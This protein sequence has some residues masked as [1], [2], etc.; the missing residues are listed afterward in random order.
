L[1]DTAAPQTAQ[2]FAAIQLD[3]TDEL[4]RAVLP[5]LLALDVPPHDA[6]APLVAALRGWSGAMEMN[7]AQPLIFNAWM[8]SFVAAVQRRNKIP[9]DDDA[10][11]PD[12]LEASLLGADA[13]PA[14]I[15]LLCGTNCDAALLDALH[16]ATKRLTK[17]FGADPA[18]WSWGQAHPAIFAHPILGRLPYIG[19]LG[20]FSIPDPGDA[21]TIDAAAPGSAPGD[22]AGFA[23][24]HGPELRAVFD[25]AN[26]DASRFILAPGQS[27]NL[28]SGNAGNLVSAWRDG[29]TVEL[30]PA[31]ASAAGWVAMSPAE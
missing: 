4:A 11:Q 20:R 21:N 28:L 29:W 18:A 13:S 23:A 9:P 6:G 10:V 14:Q 30:G 16:H 12:N 22:A 19:G 26:L 5:R 17:F 31:P 15:A 3:V 2:N 25:L 27:G 8:E 24:I 7:E 1:L